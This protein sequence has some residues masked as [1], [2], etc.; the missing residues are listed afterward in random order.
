MGVMNGVSGKE[1]G[2]LI[3]DIDGSSITVA[4]VTVDSGLNQLVL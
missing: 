1:E 3:L 2:Y 4:F